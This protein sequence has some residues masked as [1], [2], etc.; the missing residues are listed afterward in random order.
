MFAFITGKGTSKS[1][2]RFTEFNKILRDHEKNPERFLDT[3]ESF[4]KL[5]HFKN[6]SFYLYE[7]KTNLFLLK[8]WVGDKPVRFS[9]SAEYEFVKYLK[10]RNSAVSRRDFVQKSNEM[11]QP[12]LFFFQQTSSN[13]ICPLI[14]KDNWFGYLA[15]YDETLKSEELGEVELALLEMYCYAFKIWLYTNSLQDKNKKLSELSHVKNQLLANVTH[16]LQTPLSGILG[17]AQVLLD[18]NQKPALSKNQLKQVKIIQNSAKDLHST[19]NNFLRLIQIEAKKNEIKFQKVDFQSLLFE[20]LNLF[21]N[22]FEEKNNQVEI[23][24]EPQNAIVFVEPDQLRTVLMN[25]IANANKFTQNGLISI[26]W[27]KSGEMLQVSIQDTGV[28]ISEDKLDLIFEEFF[29]EDGSHT[30]LYGGTGLG[31]AIVKK[32]ISVHQGRIWV[33]SQ[34]N[35]GAKFTFTVPLVPSPK[36]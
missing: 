7:P 26:D 35:V 22:S 21:E 27:R 8:K 4:I 36:H 14:Y 18:D 12:A 11:R 33:E 24:K 19:V 15:F 20:V 13:L 5:V 3:L 31:L 23:P 6:A 30:R 9:V 1:S 2:N 25:L 16:E 28:G 34:K 32:I 29:Q 17:M 10:V